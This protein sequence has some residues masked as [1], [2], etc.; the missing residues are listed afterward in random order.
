MGPK[1]N[2]DQQALVVPVTSSPK[3]VKEV[4]HLE[5]PAYIR[6]RVL[7]VFVCMLAVCVCHSSCA[8]AGMLLVNIPNTDIGPSSAESADVFSR[9]LVC[10]SRQRSSGKDDLAAVILNS[11]D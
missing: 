3:W 10:N 7:C 2:L 9:P 1:A 6:L 5:S 11:V 8:D 4:A